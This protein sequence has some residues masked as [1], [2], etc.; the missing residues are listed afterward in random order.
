VSLFVAF[1]LVLSVLVAGGRE[2][3]GAP[4]SA[5]KS[6]NLPA[7]VT[8]SE[9][10]IRWRSDGGDGCAKVGGC[11][12]Y[13]IIFRGDGFVELEELPWVPPR[14]KPAIRRRSIDPSQIVELINELFKARFLE[15]LDN[16]HGVSVAIQKG[17]ILTFGSRGGVGGGWVDLTLRIGSM[18][19]TVRLGEDPPIEMRSVS[20]RIWRLAGP[21]SWGP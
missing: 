19:K 11:S 2:Q 3:A 14:P 12:H 9:V 6:M 15:A 4:I 5:G 20:E 13:Q 10:E 18:E 7:S 21:E 1:A 17:D 16:Y 8:L